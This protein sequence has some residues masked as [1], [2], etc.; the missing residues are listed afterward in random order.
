MDHGLTRKW[1]QKSCTSG[2]WFVSF[3][4]PLLHAILK[5]ICDQEAEKLEKLK[6]EV[7]KDHQEEINFHE[8]SIKDLQEQIKR[9]AEKINRYQKKLEDQ[10][11]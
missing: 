9:H 10:K 3:G 7:L 11:K 5:N 2:N 6:K 4:S 1:L 8:E